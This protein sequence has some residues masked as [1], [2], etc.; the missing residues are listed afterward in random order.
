MD[1]KL[2]V[3]FGMEKGLVPFGSW[4]SQNI[5]LRPLR[6]EDVENGED[7]NISYN[8][9][10]DLKPNHSRNA[11]NKSLFL[12]PNTSFIPKISI[13]SEVQLFSKYLLF[14]Y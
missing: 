11:N 14:L 1:G 5:R 3:E 8:H 12:P 10:Q 13:Y 7:P 2:Q 9:L 6:D 4:K